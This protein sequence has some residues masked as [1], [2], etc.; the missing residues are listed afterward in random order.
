MKRALLALAP[1]SRRARAR[2]LVAASLVP[3][4]CGGSAAAPDPPA[5]PVRVAAGGSALVDVG[6]QAWTG[7]RGFTGG[8]AVSTSTRVAGTGTP[9][10]YARAR[11]GMTGWSVRVPA[12]ATYA[13]TLHFAETGG[14]EPG[15]R[16]FG[17][18]AEGRPV[19][20]GVDAAREAGAAT[21]AAAVFTVPVT[22]GRLNLRFL[23]EAGTPRVSGIEVHRYKASVRPERTLFEDTFA[24]AA[25]RAPDPRRWGADVRAPRDGELQDY[26]DARDVAALDGRGHLRL[27][28]R[29][30]GTGY[31]SARIQTYDRFGFTYGRAAFRLRVPRGQGLWPAAWLLGEQAYRRQAFPD[32]GEI[33]ALEAYGDST[34]IAR[35]SIHGPD[36]Q[37]M[38]YGVTRRTRAARD[39]ADGWHTVAVL[40]TPDAVQFTLDGRRTAA[41]TAADLAPGQRWTLDQRH[42]LLLN[43]AVGGAAGAPGP[44]TP[45]PARFVVDRVRVAR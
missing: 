19:L 42:F 31:R 15:Q 39:L 44:D 45:F 10:L 5:L 20:R 18:E 24:G 25:G 13:V 17:V 36:Q 43:L 37:G 4:A 21:A 6:G 16:V 29:R 41:I 35:Q 3:L 32:S 22:D 30:A 38:A 27:T 2:A 40:W 7:D 14:A 12:A 23:A 28:A 8:R 33:D 1:P 34:G 26:A 9:E 11:E